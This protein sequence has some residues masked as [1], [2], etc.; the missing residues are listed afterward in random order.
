MKELRLRELEGVTVREL[1]KEQRFFETNGK[2]TTIF[3][4]GGSEEG[5]TVT[6]YFNYIAEFIFQDLKTRG[7]CPEVNDLVSSCYNYP[8][9]WRIV[10]IVWQYDEDLSGDLTRVAFEIEGID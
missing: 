7:R 2:K 10:S 5:E 3:K 9:K 1:N 8:E 4:K 6:C